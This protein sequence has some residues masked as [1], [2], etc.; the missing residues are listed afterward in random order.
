MVDLEK[1][2]LAGAATLFAQKNVFVFA[3]ATPVCR[4]QNVLQDPLSGI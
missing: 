3:F 2:A 4:F 1:R